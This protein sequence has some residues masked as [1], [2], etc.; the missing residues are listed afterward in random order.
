[1]ATKVKVNVR[2]VPT[3]GQTTTTTVEVKATGTKLKDVLK[4]AK[5]SPKNKDLLVNGK[6]ATLDTFVC[7]G[8]NVATRDVK[9]EVSERPQGS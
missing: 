6:P 5:I 7:D 9:V 3:Q 2:V 4:A 1:M 8:D